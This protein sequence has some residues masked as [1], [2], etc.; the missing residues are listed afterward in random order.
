V[1]KFNRGDKGQKGPIIPPKRK[2]PPTKKGGGNYSINLNWER[3]GT[4]L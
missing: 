1:D 3:V 2:T 4:V